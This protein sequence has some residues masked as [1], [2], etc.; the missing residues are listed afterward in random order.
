MVLSEIEEHLRRFVGREVVL[1]HYIEFASILRLRITH[2]TECDW[3]LSFAGCTYIRG[4]VRWQLGELDFS[5]NEAEF[6]VVED[7]TVDFSVVCD[8]CHLI[9]EKEY[10]NTI[11]RREVERL[12]GTTS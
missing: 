5:R 2:P 12:K 9:T 1:H 10:S 8:S 11:L 7:G 3:Y 6:L 4:P